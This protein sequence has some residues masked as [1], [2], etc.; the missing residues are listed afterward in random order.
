[1]PVV[2]T[3]P[4]DGALCL[5]CVNARMERRPLTNSTIATTNLELLHV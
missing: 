3:A 4:V 1:M 2:D 5:P